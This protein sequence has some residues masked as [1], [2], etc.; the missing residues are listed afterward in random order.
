MAA[1]SETPRGSTPVGFYV[2]DTISGRMMLIDTGTMRSVFLP[3]R[4]DRRLP[5]DLAT[6][7]M[8]ANR[9]PILS[10]GTRLLSFSILGWR[11]KWNFIVA[12]VRTPLLGAE[13]LAHF[14]LAVD[15]SRKRLLDTESCQSLPLSPGPRE[16]TTYS[17]SPHQYGSLLNEF[18]EVFKPELCQVPGAPAKH[19]IYHDTKTK[20]PPDVCEVPEGSPTAPSGGQEGLS[21]DGTDG[22]MQEGSQPMGLP[23]SHGAESGQHLETLWRLQAA[24]PRY[25]T[26]KL[27][28]TKHAGPNGLLPW[29][30]IFSKLDLLKSYFQV[31]V[32]P[33]DIH[34]TAIITPFRSYIFS[35]FTFSLRNAGM[36]FQTLVDSI[37]GDLDFCCTFSV[38]KVEFL[39]HEI[40][41]GSVRPVLSKVEAV[42]RSPTPTSIRAVQ[43]FLG[44]VNYYRRFIPGL[45]TPWPPDGGPQWLSEDFLL[46]GKPFSIWTVHQL[47]VHAFTKLG[48]AC[49]SR[50]QRHLAAVAEFT[51]TIKYLPNKKNTVADALLR[52]EIDTEQLR[53]NYEDLSREQAADPE[54]PTYCTAAMSLK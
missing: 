54:T 37:L 49:C 21:R 11:Y 14:G 18:L 20:G 44:M 3:S 32:V 24:Q 30:K 52:V 34:K 4:E 10:Y 38:E 22:H 17:V 28:S 27:P 8:A 53:I 13:F 46:E 50:Q 16:P 19:G 41:P 33:E 1:A 35:F 2:R 15:V 31:P 51:C 43:E 42:V 26:R 47:L 23:P 39:G 29:A 25:R 9:S 45:R 40:S 6:S 48:D 5:P 36:T 7:L 12:D